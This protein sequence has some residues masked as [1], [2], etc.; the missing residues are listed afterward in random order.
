MKRIVVILSLA[1]TA[2]AAFGELNVGG[3]ASFET[4]RPPIFPILPQLFIQNMYRVGPWQAFGLDL[5]VA[6]SPVSSSYGVTSGPFVSVG[7]D[8]AY[9]FPMLGPVEPMALV[10]G[11]AFGDYHR[12]VNGAAA[13][14]GAGAT[15][16]VSGFFV[17]GRLLYRFFSS[18]GTY[19]P[20]EPLG[21]VSI[22]LLGG[23][24]L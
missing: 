12:R 20:S 16:R 5:A 3:G 11:E 7:A 13:Q 2:A 19:G 9:L 14:V 24:T 23:V 15:M 10:G 21:I 4:G 6:A 8:A 17:Q 1:L 18:T 22:A